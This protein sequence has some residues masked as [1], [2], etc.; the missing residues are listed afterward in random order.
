VIH[1]RGKVIPVIDLR[2][3]LGLEEIGYTEQTCIIVVDA[4]QAI[5]IIVDAVS[6]VLDI[7]GWNIEP[8]PAAG[9]SMD[10]AFILG[11]G[12][13]FIFFHVLWQA[14]VLVCCLYLYSLP[15]FK[16]FLKIKQQELPIYLQV[17]LLAV[18]VAM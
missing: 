8:P 16:K 4:G 15:L 10:S 18:Y 3:Q 1:L 13:T 7:P 2:L 5:G 6:E 17:F 9:V 11:M 12:H 14:Q